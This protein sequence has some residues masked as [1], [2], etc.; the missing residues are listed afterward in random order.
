[1]LS[2]SLRILGL[3]ALVAAA[4]Q[5]G[6]ALASRPTVQFRFLHES[7]EMGE[8]A[9]ITYRVQH[10]PGGSRLVFQ[11]QVGT[12]QV[13]RTILV[14]SP[15]ATTANL[16]PVSQG[17]HT[18]RL[19]LIGRGGRSIAT[20]VHSLKVYGA[21]PL[22]TLLGKRTETVDIGGTLFRYVA[23]LNSN[24]GG[25]IG[26]NNCGFLGRTC[27]VF[28]LVGSTC[29]SLTLQLASQ[30]QASDAEPPAIT[31]ASERADPVNVQVP[32]NMS[33]EVHAAIVGDVELTYALQ[34]AKGGLYFN[35]SANCY[36]PSGQ[37]R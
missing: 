13:W 4:L 37:P 27:E 24:F 21:V 20:V 2:R 31:V 14:L 8:P 33:T 18:L 12:A 35:G 23:G 3:F 25:Y 36:T 11:R 16:P 28:K 32:L 6:V 17:Q 1:M 26:S 30:T 19:A 29:R 22:A 34:G 7:V 10:V 15:H 9:A 5:P